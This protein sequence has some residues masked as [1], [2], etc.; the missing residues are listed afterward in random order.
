M[1]S[2]LIGRVLR[3]P[4]ATEAANGFSFIG[5]A[6]EKGQ[7]TGYLKHL[8]NLTSGI[9]DL[10]LPAHTRRCDVASCQFAQTLF[11]HQRGGL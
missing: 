5:K 6:C 2:A 8:L 9:E 11:A 1:I 7:E 4:L 10:Y 3:G